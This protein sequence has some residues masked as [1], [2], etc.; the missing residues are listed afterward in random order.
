MNLERSIG[1]VRYMIN[2]FINSFFIQ[3][4]YDLFLLIFYIFKSS[5]LLKKIYYD[6]NNNME[7]IESDGLW[8][9]IMMEMTILCLANSEN[10]MN[11]LC[12]SYPIK[13]KYYPAILF[14]IL[15]VCNFTIKFDLVAGIVYAFIYVYYLRNYLD[16]DEQTIEKIEGSFLFNYTKNYPSFVKKSNVDASLLLGNDMNNINNYN[17]INY[18]GIKELNT[19]PKV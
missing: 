6:K 18:N 10:E 14:L 15:T 17:E 2:F 7:Y 3:L 19:N 5:I 4:L 11:I 12:F 8:P 16:F 13:S 9:Y 1:T